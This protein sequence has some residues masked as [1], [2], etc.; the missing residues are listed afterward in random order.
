L[1]VSASSSGALANSIVQFLLYHAANTP[2]KIDPMTGNRILSHSKGYASAGIL[3]FGMALMMVLIS[4][5]APPWGDLAETIAFLAAL[6]LLIIVGI[7][8]LLVTTISRVIVSENGIAVRTPW[9]FRIVNWE[10]ISRI[11]YFWLSESLVITTHKG[12][13]VRVSPGYNGI[14]YLVERFDERLQEHIFSDK[15]REVI[16][17]VKS[18]IKKK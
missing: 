17:E 16:E 13:K 18:K 1:A 14:A 11:H 6:V 2:P 12:M 8:T 9:Y 15:A 5:V 4:R 3:C 7:L 10:D